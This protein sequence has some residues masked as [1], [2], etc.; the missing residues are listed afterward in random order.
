MVWLK[1]VQTT[2][3]AEAHS[4]PMQSFG[5]TSSKSLLGAPYTGTAVSKYS[6]TSS[7]PSAMWELDS[8]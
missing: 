4:K 8:A 2:R 1:V 3:Y 5:A 7:K 6:A